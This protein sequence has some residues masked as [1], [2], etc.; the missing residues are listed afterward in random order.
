MTAVADPMVAPLAV[1]VLACLT[2]EL[3]QVAD[4][5]QTTMLR[6]GSG[7]ELLM[8]T[9][10]DECCTGLGW[11]RVMTVYPSAQFPEPDGGYSVE[12]PVQWAVVLELGAARCAPRPG[13]AVIPSADVWN[14]V[15]ASVLDDAAAIRRAICCW[16]A[17]NADQMYVA[18]PWIPLTTEGGCV[19]GAHTLTIAVP[20]CDC[21]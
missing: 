6:P 19:G 10:T 18:G 15:T 7:I 13:P 21:D 16:A 8:S 20:A 11:V 3:A 5:P 12:E 17:A 1:D 2:T 4:P 9:T 14:T